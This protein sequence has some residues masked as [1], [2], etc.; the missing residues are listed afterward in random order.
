MKLLTI[1]IAGYNVEKFIKQ[2]LDSLCCKNIEK[3]EIF[4]VDDGGK[5][6]TLQIAKS[7]AQKF[8]DSI[9]PV[10]KNN[11]GWGSTVN[12]SI[13]HATGKYFKLLDGDDFFDTQNLDILLDYLETAN[14]DVIYSP[15]RL[16]DDHTGKTVEVSDLSKDYDLFNTYT[17]KDLNIMEGLEM[18]AVA[19]K[20]SILQGHHVRVTEKCF[21]TDNEYRTK[22]LAYCSNITFTNLCLYQYRIGREGQSVDVVGMKKH[23]KDSIAVAKVLISFHKSLKGDTF[24]IIDYCIKNAIDFAYRMLIVIQEKEDL[25]IFDKHIKAEGT[26]YYKCQQKNVNLLRKLNF[27]ALKYISM[28]TRLRIALNPIIKKFK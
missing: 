16:F 28:M 25:L 20:T 5:D 15:Y 8:P 18:H 14:S 23:Y 12:Y 3:L 10:H 11:G 21:Y 2:T 17:L 26:F 7:Y 1:S 19:F 13:E 27:K 6:Q 24:P 22:G 4:V 9:I